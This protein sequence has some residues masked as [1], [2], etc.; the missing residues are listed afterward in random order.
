MEKLRYGDMDM[1]RYRDLEI[2]DMRQRTWYKDEGYRGGIK[3]LRNLGDLKN[4]R[5]FRGFRD[6]D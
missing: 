4:Y 1:W 6:F 5:D 2:G 3:G